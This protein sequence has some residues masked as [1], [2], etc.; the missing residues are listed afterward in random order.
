MRRR[1]IAERLA[2]R[3]IGSKL[4]FASGFAGCAVLGV[5]SSWF[6]S[7]L[8]LASSWLVPVALLIKKDEC[9]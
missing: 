8:D 4:G 6:Q 3:S 2:A 1:F 5:T 7:I 9:E